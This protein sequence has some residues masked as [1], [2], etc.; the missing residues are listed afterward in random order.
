MSEIPLK[1]KPQVFVVSPA[2]LIY[3]SP[4][5]FFK[6]GFAALKN[7]LAPCEF[8]RR[9]EQFIGW[10]MEP[11]SQRTLWN[12]LVAFLAGDEAWRTR[13]NL[14]IESA[15]P[16]FGGLKSPDLTIS[17]RFQT[18]RS[19]SRGASRGHPKIIPHLA[20]KPY[21]TSACSKH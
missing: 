16:R 13:C 7:R 17:G 10:F 20:E 9:A 21:L 15:I 14:R 3:C 11:S 19:T 2:Q 4:A 8:E 12:E 18:P 6:V 5:L 1:P